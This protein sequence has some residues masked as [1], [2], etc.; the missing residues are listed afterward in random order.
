MLL[1][2]AELE[3]ADLAAALGGRQDGALMAEAASALSLTL[4][5]IGFGVQLNSPLVGFVPI[6]VLF[7]PGA[8]SRRE[9][10]RLLEPVRERI[11]PSGW[12]SRSR[13]LTATPVHSET[14]CALLRTP[15]AGSREGALMHRLLLQ[16]PGKHGATV[17]GQ[18]LSRLRFL[19]TVS[20]HQPSIGRFLPGMH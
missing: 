18:P 8:V 13:Q 12:R 20:Q 19:S 6:F 2:A 11:L 5:F 4:A 9:C 14:V 3:R 7:P 17:A 15:R 10:L 16:P 1:R